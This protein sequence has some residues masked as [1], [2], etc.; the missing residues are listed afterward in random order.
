MPRVRRPA[1]P[2]AGACQSDRCARASSRPPPAQE[3]NLR[4]RTPENGSSTRAKCADPLSFGAL[5]EEAPSD[6]PVGLGDR[7]CRESACTMAGRPQCL[8]PADRCSHLPREIRPL[9]FPA[10]SNLPGVFIYYRAEDRLGREPPLESRQ[11]PSLTEKRD[12]ETKGKWGARG[13][14][15]HG[16]LWCGAAQQRVCSDRRPG[17]CQRRSRGSGIGAEEGADAGGLAEAGGCGGSSPRASPPDSAWPRTPCGHK[18]RRKFRG[19]PDLM[20]PYVLK[21]IDPDFSA[22]WRRSRQA[23]R[24]CGCA[25][26]RAR[27]AQGGEGA[28]RR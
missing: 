1:T 5:M 14:L 17:R 19:I 10:L 20:L 22:L 26:G 11:N 3:E 9:G 2:S 24:R 8:T 13:R 16:A 6:A 7:A 4:R 18:G 25:R 12:C 23:S 28:W 21:Y 15:L 27:R